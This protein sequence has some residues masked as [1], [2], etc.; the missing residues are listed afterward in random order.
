M[1][2]SKFQEQASNISS[3]KFSV[4]INSFHML[5][6]CSVF[7]KHFNYYFFVMFWQ[8]N[9]SIQRCSNVV[10]FNELSSVSF[11]VFFILNIFFFTN[12]QFHLGSNVCLNVA[13]IFF[14]N[15]FMN[16]NIIVTYIKHLISPCSL[17]LRT[18]NGVQPTNNCQPTQSDC[19]CCNMHLFN[20]LSLNSSS[21]I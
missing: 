11:S 6:K 15:S 17:N 13:L 18:L 7:V 14:F 9:S 16:V 12:T 3:V 10:Y 2:L 21:L 1:Y 5:V 8:K 19:S 4:M 20:V